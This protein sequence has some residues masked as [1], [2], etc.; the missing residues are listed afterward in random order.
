MTINTTQVTIP[1]WLK[2]MSFFTFFKE[3]NH[4][5]SHWT[6]TFILFKDTSHHHVNHRYANHHYESIR[7][8]PLSSVTAKTSHTNWKHATNCHSVTLHVLI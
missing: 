4:F 5:F 8:L 1:Q 7:P 3:F 2:S 6:E